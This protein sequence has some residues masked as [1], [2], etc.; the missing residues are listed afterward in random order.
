MATRQQKNV[1]FAFLQPTPKKKKKAE[2]PKAQSPQKLPQQ[3]E[4][5]GRS[6]SRPPG[7]AAG[8]DRLGPHLR[9]AQLPAAGHGGL[10]VLGG[11]E[12]KLSVFPPPPPRRVFEACF[13]LRGRGGRAS[14]KNGSPA[15]PGGFCASSSVLGFSEGNPPTAWAFLGWIPINFADFSKTGTQKKDGVVGV[16]F[17][18]SSS[19]SSSFLGFMV[20]DS[21]L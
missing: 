12:E 8:P 18:V 21:K 14:Q 15:T 5:R 9:L 2:P 13:G 4:A 17:C 6:G 19:S 1:F 11:L 3:G 7:Q 20:L 16:V 10:H